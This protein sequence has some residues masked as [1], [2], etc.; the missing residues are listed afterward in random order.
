MFTPINLQP[1][2]KAL[3]SDGSFLEVQS[4]F[5]TIQG[6]GPFAGRPAVFIRLAGC[7][8]QCPSC[9][10][11]YTSKREMYPYLAIVQE[12]KKL[13]ASSWL[14]VITGG[15]PFRQNI[16]HL[17]R[18]LR[19]AD[20]IVQI[21]TN[22]SLPPPIGLPLE[23]WVV[24]SPKTGKVHPRIVDIADCYKYVLSHDS[25]DPNDG[26]PILALNHTASPK[27]FRPVNICPDYVYVQPMD[28][29]DERTNKLNIQAVKESCMKHGYIMQLQIHKIIGV[30]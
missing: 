10:T 2:E 6:E 4:I 13:R 9:D 1:I 7:N 18:E 20:Y 5:D 23:T 26:L 11:D 15:E 29:Q 24:C 30:E 25:V 17:V 28:S 21:E 22:G 16:V 27:V 3:R 8:L 14:V 19:K 12:V